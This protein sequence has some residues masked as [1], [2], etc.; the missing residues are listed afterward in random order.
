MDPLSEAKE[1]VVSVST[2]DIHE[3]IRTLAS[4]LYSYVEEAL[5]VHEDHD[6]V[7]CEFEVFAHD[8]L[9]VLMRHA[10]QL[11]DNEPNSFDLREN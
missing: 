2:D 5:V 4:A 1:Y 3:A 6:S 8:L 7:E 11:S 9:G 10:E